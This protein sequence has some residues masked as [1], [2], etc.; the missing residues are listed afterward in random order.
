MVGRI[1][2]ASLLLVS[3]C[4]PSAGLDAGL[5]R[6]APDAS[7]ADAPERLDVSITTDVPPDA[8]AA[9]VFGAAVAGTLGPG[10]TA[11]HAFHG[12]A[13]DWVYLAA[14]EG[15]GPPDPTLALTTIGGARLAYSE[16]FVD[17]DDAAMIITRLASS[18]LHW[19]E[20]AL[21]PGREG[22]GRYTLDSA[23]L[24]ASSAITI[25]HELGDD[26]ASATPF[27]TTATYL[28]GSFEHADDV[29]LFDL[30][31]S[32]FAGSGTPMVILDMLPSGPNGNGSSSVPATVGLLDASGARLI[33]WTPTG[34]EEH[35]EL[36]SDD[37]LGGF[38]EVR[39]GAAPG[40]H[41]LYVM[42]VFVTRMER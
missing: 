16:D 26:L 38:V 4:V 39:A 14:G 13:G 7:L 11:R 6:D 8:P 36:G 5:T 15:G 24:S 20:V 12:T 40:A 33:E 27:E 41:G 34:D 31:D 3:A 19:V 25:D 23:V 32:A 2:L 21:E 1:A 35:M 42:R 30:P 37:L 29:D 18:G 10:E 17:S 9:H 28:A 22:D